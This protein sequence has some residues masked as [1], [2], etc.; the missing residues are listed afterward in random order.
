MPGWPIPDDWD[1]EGDGQAIAFFCFPNS[2]KWRAIVRGH[3]DTFTYGRAWDGKTGRVLDAL[4]GARIVTGSVCIMSCEELNAN[5][6]RIAS[7]LE[8][9]DTKTAEFITWQDI[10]TDLQVTLGIAHPLYLV[11]KALTDLI[12]SLKVKADATQVLK[13]IWEYITWKGPILGLLGTIATSQVAIAASTVGGGFLAFMNGQLQ[14]LQGWLTWGVDL[15]QGNLDFWDDWFKPLM[16][17]FIPDSEGGTGGTDP[18]NDPELRILQ[19]G[20]TIHADGYQA[21]TTALS[22]INLNIADKTVLQQQIATLQ[23]MSDAIE[24]RIAELVQATNELCTCGAM[25][26]SGCCCGG[27]I[28]PSPGVI[29]DPGELTANCPPT[30]FV[31]IPEFWDYK[32]RAA[33]WIA[34]KMIETVNSLK[35]LQSNVLEHY[36]SASSQAATSATLVYSSMAGGVANYTTQLIYLNMSQA[37]L[38]GMIQDLTSYYFSFEADYLTRVPETDPGSVVV[39]EWFDVLGDIAQE[40]LDNYWDTIL[41]ELYSQQ[42]SASTFVSYLQG[43]INSAVD[44][45]SV[46]QTVNEP[47]LLKNILAALPTVGLL[48]S[49]YYK[50]PIMVSYPAP[51]GHGCTDPCGSP[52][53]CIASIDAGYYQGADIYAAMDVSGTYTIDIDM[54]GDGHEANFV[55]WSE[56]G[57]TLTLYDDLGAQI[58]QSTTLPGSG[59]IVGRIL[60]TWSSFFTLEILFSCGGA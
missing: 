41:C 9:I 6:D 12:P 46:G 27:G 48:N 53:A 23:D 8:S 40:L 13:S 43:Q 47:T 42:D 3:L 29:V 49:L 37:T 33:S 39:A 19:A 34:D 24:N 59:V 56:S 26:G 50:Q 14:I 36:L 30:G 57:P 52:V 58:Y 2:Q 31:D 35:N 4:Y 21:L 15:F 38:Q 10:L 28:S 25:G 54:D 51:T 60:A 17:K 45:V 18:D 44:A 5:L 20:N 32:I 22:N 1:E 7:A 55:A 11:V 16:D